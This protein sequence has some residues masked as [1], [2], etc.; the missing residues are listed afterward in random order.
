LDEVLQPLPI[1]VSG[2]LYIA[3]RTCA[4]LS[5]RGGL[6]G[7]IVRPFDGERLY[8]TGDLVVICDGDLSFG[9]IDHQVKSASGSSLE[10]RR[11]W[12]SMRVSRSV[13]IAPRM[14]PN[15]AAGAIVCPRHGWLQS[16]RL[17]DVAR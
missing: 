5:F 16:S 7:A 15:K 13:V 6:T 11:G 4:G 14:W 3:G 10:I 2:E 8:R 17:F 9:A 1:G 12:L